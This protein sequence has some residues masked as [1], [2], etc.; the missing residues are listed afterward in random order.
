MKTKIFLILLF[1]ASFA[2]AQ[3]VSLFDALAPRE[4]YTTA[5]MN[6]LD[7]REGLMIYN[8]DTESY[9][10]YDGTAWAEAASG[11][12]G[13]LTTDQQN[14]LANANK[15]PLDSVITSAVDSLYVWYSEYTTSGANIGRKKK[16]RKDNGRVDFYPPSTIIPINQAWRFTAS[17]ANDT[18]AFN[19]G[20][21]YVIWFPEQTAG[22]GAYITGPYRDAYVDKIS[23]DTLRVIADEITSFVSE[24]TPVV[25]YYAFNAATVVPNEANDT[26]GFTLT[27][28]ESDHVSV[29]STGSLFSDGLYSIAVTCVETVSSSNS[30]GVQ[31]ELTG[32]TPGQNYVVSVKVRMNPGNSIN[33]NSG[34][35]TSEGWN[36][37][38][39]DFIINP[40][41]DSWDS[42]SW[43]SSPTGT[44]AFVRFTGTSSFSLNEV[45]YI[46]EVTVA[47][48]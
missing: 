12:G 37:A 40:S 3:R 48:Q 19:P 34:L 44:S 45:F 7:T 17:G 41:T 10:V 47:E 14:I 32:L 16:L 13:A 42:Y 43:V 33:I 5:Q 2:T 15:P 9:W 29:S 35:Y 21:G 24:S 36:T 28:S 39:T 18:I 26:D 8:S 31:L 27:G 38:D 20:N 30:A 6:A 1:V 25:N 23:S 4:S 11:D 46:D 22:D